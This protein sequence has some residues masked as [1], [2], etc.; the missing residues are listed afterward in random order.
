MPATTRRDAA[1][2]RDRLVV[3]ARQTFA[4]LGPDAP[5]DAIARA[6]GVS[7][8]TL[9]R[10]FLDREELAGAVLE[11][12]VGDIETRAAD[13][14][15]TVGGAEAL[16]HHMLDIQLDA[17]WLARAVAR[18]GASG[19]GE[20]ARRTAAALDPLVAQ[21]REHGRLQPGVTTDDLLSALPMAMAAQAAVEH[22]ASETDPRMLDRTRAILHRG[23]FT[24]APPARPA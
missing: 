22:G 16:F 5:L 20:L 4:V 7:R 15:G 1:R 9:H 13:L 17:P 3:A 6:A 8:T 21:A 12:N 19:V 14:E 24:T 11:Q 10:H 23:L 2:N 18:R